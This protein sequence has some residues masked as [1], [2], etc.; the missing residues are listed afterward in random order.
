V[1]AA[2]FLMTRH[3]ERLRHTTEQRFDRLEKVT[4]QALA[5]H[6]A[7]FDRLEKVTRQA[8]AD[9]GAR[10][11]K[12]I[13]QLT[14]TQVLYRRV[15][16][17]VSSGGRVPFNRELPPE[18]PPVEVSVVDDPGTN[19]PPGP[20]LSLRACPICGD[21]HHTP[22]CRFNKMITMRRMPDKAAAHYA[23]SLCHGCGVVYASLRPA[24]PRFTWLLEHFEE[25]L[26]RAEA[27]T[28]R[29]GK[30]V[31]NSYALDDD[32]RAR[33]RALA[34]K[35]VFVSEHEGGNSR[36]HL[37]HLMSD[38]MANSRHIETIGS[39]LDLKAPRVLEIRSRLG[40]ILAGLRR[41]YDAEP[42]AI[43]MFPSQRFLI[44]E[45]YG[46]PAEA[47][48][49]F[50]HFTIPYEPPFDLVVSNH[51]LT[52]A[53]RPKEFL[54]TVRN[55]LVPGGHLYLYNEPLEEEFLLHEKS[56]FNTLNAFHLQAFN[57]ESFVRALNANGFE[58][59]Y[60]G[61]QELSLVCLARRTEGPVDWSPMPERERASRRLAY[62]SA[63]ELS[64]LRLPEHV[65]SRC[66]DRWQG[67]I[68][69]GLEKGFV[70]ADHRGRLRLML[71]TA[72]M[73]A[74]AID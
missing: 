66:A 52:H 59:I 37:P 19:C 10:I 50:D 60:L 74:D 18:L 53:V 20:V 57:R 16:G 58:V 13:G 56:M 3:L 72:A 54:E 29:A 67:A 21:E 62:R 38:R 28:R 1:V 34:S 14:R 32:G 11:D 47:R 25:S 70:A 49:D 61:S 5:D 73:R 33:L 43:P 46:I 4:R 23:Y 17:G 35:G 6:G 8:L 15:A 40:S 7:R 26:G 2:P 63:E 68:A 45:V 9:H 69:H 31:L 64:I 41:L 24:G 51:M 22:V 48:L 39:L 27:G 30:V 44:Q 42:F 65:R 36:D 71:R 55:A 12:Q